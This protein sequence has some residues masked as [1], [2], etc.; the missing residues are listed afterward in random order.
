MRFRLLSSG[1]C[2]CCCC[3]WVALMLLL[4]L[5]LLLFV[6]DVELLLLLLLLLLLFVADVELLLLLLLLLWWPPE[7]PSLRLMERRLM[8]LEFIRNFWQLE[9]LEKV[10]W[11]VAMVAD[12]FEIRLERILSILKS[13]L[14]V[15][16]VLLLFF[17]ILFIFYFIVY[18]LIYFRMFILNDFLDDYLSLFWCRNSLK[19]WF[20]LFVIIH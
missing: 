8:K 1:G 6:A 15:S 19:S 7:Y 11:S 5:L 2:C 13:V 18:L 9:F 20:F 16:C 14:W 4:L 3:C 17:I 12:H 10:G